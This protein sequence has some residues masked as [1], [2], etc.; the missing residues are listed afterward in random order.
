[1]SIKGKVALVTGASSGIGEG[2]ARA[3][4]ANGVKVGLAARRI[5]RLRRI[6]EEIRA[7]G[8]EAM[9][10]QLDVTQPEQNAAAVKP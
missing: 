10:I 9:A 5:D 2:T 4:A 8:G 7:A 3:L 1:M 6:A